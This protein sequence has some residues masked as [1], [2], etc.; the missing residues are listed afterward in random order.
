LRDGKR[1]LAKS[2]ASTSVDGVASPGVWTLGDAEG[3][4]QVTASVEAAKIVLHATATGTTVRFA[5]VAVATTQGGTC[6]L[7]NDQFVSCFGQP[8]P[9]GTGDS[10]NTSTPTLTK[11]GIHLTSVV[12]AGAGAHFC[13]TATD[14]SIYCWGTTALV[15]TAGSGQQFFAHSTP[16]QHWV[17][18]GHPGSQHNCALATIDR[19]LLGH[20]YVRPARRQSNDASLRS[21]QA[22]RRL[23]SCSPRGGCLA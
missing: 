12:G 3:D 2:V 16:E 21:Q 14:L 15:D 10:L 18:P 6:A 19:V 22:G 7:T 1:R 5:A 8:P 4:Q 13:G 11:G 20:R 9:D 23:Q 17:D